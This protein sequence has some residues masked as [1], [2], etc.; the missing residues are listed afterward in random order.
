MSVYGQGSTTFPVRNLQPRAKTPFP[1]SSHLATPSPLNG[2][3][4]GVRGVTNSGVPEH[5]T[6]NIELPTL[7]LRSAPRTLHLEPRTAFD[8]S[9]R[10]CP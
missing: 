8:S 9:P 4:V 10:P 7:N 3:R 1:L 2:E 6:S 5:R